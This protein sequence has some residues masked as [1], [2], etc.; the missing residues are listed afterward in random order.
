MK[1]QVA[2]LMMIFSFQFS[3]QAADIVLQ[4]GGP[5]VNIGGTTVQCGGSASTLP[6]CYYG[7]DAT[8]AHDYYVISGTKIL[9]VFDSNW[10]LSN[11]EDTLEFYMNATKSQICVAGG[12]VKF[13]SYGSVLEAIIDGKTVTISR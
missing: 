3:A 13:R 7:F 11:P 4:P 9:Q 12:E 1:T 8:N 2:L 5:E 10:T 6:K